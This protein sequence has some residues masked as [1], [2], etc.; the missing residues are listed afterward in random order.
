MAVAFAVRWVAAREAY[1]VPGDGGHFVQYGEALAHGHAKL[2]TYW[3][4]GMVL[5]AAGAERVGLDPKRTLQ[6]I[7]FVA[8]MLVVLLFGGITGRVAKSGGWGLAGGLHFI[9]ESKWVQAELSSRLGA[10]SNC[11]LFFLRLW[12]WLWINNIIW[13]VGLVY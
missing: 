11:W 8:G 2:S 12:I 9:G 1:P 3:S 5:A 4:Q 7:S 10:R 6:G 13:S